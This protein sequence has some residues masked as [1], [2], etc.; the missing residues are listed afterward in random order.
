M[1]NGDGPG[2][3]V[4]LFQGGERLWLREPIRPVAAKNAALGSIFI[5]GA[6]RTM[7]DL[8]PRILEEKAT[9]EQELSE[10]KALVRKKAEET[11]NTCTGIAA[12]IGLIPIPMSDGPLIVIT[13]LIMLKK[14]SERYERSL[15]FSTVLVLFSAMIGPV[16]FSAIIK[17]IPALG[18]I[19]GALV[20]GG[21]TLLVG[22]TAL[23]VLDAGKPFTLGNL[24]EAFVKVFKEK[25]S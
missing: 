14:L 18:S 1:A 22:Q 21:C 8:S 19:I 2:N 16:F 23:G 20:A 6:D 15:G 25:T 11:V 5:K 4:R 9:P 10:K 24:K 12:L 3:A 13:Q 17:F 7:D